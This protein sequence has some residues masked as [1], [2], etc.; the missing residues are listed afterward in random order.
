MSR[1]TLNEKLKKRDDY[2]DI[3]KRV[4]NVQNP[5]NYIMDQF[6]CSYPT[7]N[8]FY[9]EINGIPVESKKESSL[10]VANKYLSTLDYKFSEPT[11][12][13]LIQFKEELDNFS[14]E[15]IKYMFETLSNRKS[16]TDIKSLIIRAISYIIQIKYYKLIH[17]KEIP[18]SLRIKTEEVISQ[19]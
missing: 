3:I 1:I 13:T 2:Q 16:G 6:S 18:E 10:D 5:V 7:A 14:L 17:D 19:C 12:R 15:S 11:T 8:K 9:K 4:R